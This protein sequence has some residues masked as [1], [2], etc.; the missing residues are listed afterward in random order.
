MGEP[1]VGTWWRS[2]RARGQ[3]FRYRGRTSSGAY[4]FAKYSES[5]RSTVLSEIEI[6]NLD[7]M[8]PADQSIS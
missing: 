4:R 7:E 6:F 3:L 2:E 1:V 8:E 5:D